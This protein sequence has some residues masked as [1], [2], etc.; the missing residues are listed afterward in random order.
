MQLK[1]E[2]FPLLE[3]L[4]E[5]EL[6]KEDDRQLHEV[7]FELSDGDTED[8]LLHLSLEEQLVLLELS[9]MLSRLQLWLEEELD[10]ELLEGQEE[11]TLLQE[12]LSDDDKELLDDPKDVELLERQ[13]EDWLLL[14]L[15]KMLLILLEL[16]EEQP[17]LLLT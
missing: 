8:L 1:F 14:L 4:E 17:K 10:L 16:L 9:E 7:L 5:Q 6:P 13:L 12:D 2:L 3:V 15:H 11:E